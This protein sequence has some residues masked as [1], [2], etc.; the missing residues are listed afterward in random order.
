MRKAGYMTFAVG[1]WHLGQRIE[2]LPTARGFDDY[3]GIPFS[4]DMGISAWRY[5]NKSAPPF[6]ARPLPLLNGTD[7]IEQ[8][9]NL[10]TISTRY[11]DASLRFAQRARDAG[12]PFLIYLAWNHVH[13][14][15]FAAAAHCNTSRQGMVGDATQEL[16]GAIG[17]VLAGVAAMGLD[18]QT[19][20]NGA[21]LGNDRHG[22][23]PLLDGKFTTWEGGVREPAAAG[24][25]RNGEPL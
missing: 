8:P 14:P 1:K 19:V 23:G 20:D 22:N 16:D 21:P 11:V 15:N 4:C 10:A 7:I 9:A 13:N 25:A 17:Q 12:K 6:A 24:A 3:F 5:S 18:E 2:C